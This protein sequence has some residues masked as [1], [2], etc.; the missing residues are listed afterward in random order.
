[1]PA[2]GWGWNALR[3]GTIRTS[4]TV[5]NGN[6]I[7]MKLVI[8]MEGDTSAFDGGRPKKVFLLCNRKK[9]V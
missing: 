8:A 5:N 4:L 7:G 9:L 2:F 1:M 3:I 6:Y